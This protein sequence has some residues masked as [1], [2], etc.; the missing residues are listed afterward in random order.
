VVTRRTTLAVEK[1][2]GLEPADQTSSFAVLASPTPAQIRQQLEKILSSR[3]F[4]AAERQRALLRYVVEQAVQ[5]RSAAVKE[6]SVGVEAFGRGE[7]F[8]PR[9]DTI[10]RTEARNVRFRLARYYEQEGQ[11]DPIVIQLPKGGYTPRFVGQ[12]APPESPVPALAAEPNANPTPRASVTNLKRGSRI[13]ILAISVAVLAGAIAAGSLARFGRSAFVGGSPARDPASIAVLPFLNLTNDKEGE[14]LSDALAEELINSL[15]RIPGLHV[16]AGPSVFQYKDR[17]RDIAKAGR[18]LNVRN[19][20]KGSVSVSGGRV[21]ISAQLE[22]ASNGYQLWSASFDRKL[23]DLL[24]I[25]GEISRAIMQSLGVEL[26]GTTNVKAGDIPP[27]AIYQDYLKGLYFLNQST[28]ENIRTAIEYFER[29]V[30]SDPNFAPAYRGIADGYARIAAFTSTPSEEVIPKI[31][32]AATKALALDDNLGEAHL[33][34]ARAYSIEWNLPAAEREFHRALDLS[35]S[36]AAVH[37]Y[38]GEHLL[39]AGDLEKALA[40]GRIAM[41]LDPISPHSPQFVA[42]A[43]YYLRRYDDAIDQLHKAIDLHPSSGISHQLLGLVWLARSKTYAAGVSESELARKYMEGDP[44]I[45][46]QLGY[47]YAMTG[48]PAEARAILDQ[49]LA[50][51]GAYVRALPVAR[52]YIGLGDRDRAFE[53]LRKAVRQRDVSLMLKADPLYDGLRGDQ[54]FDALLREANLGA[55]PPQE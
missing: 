41:E 39:R 2:F 55:L 12:E 21:R 16:M 42:R 18:E 26:A 40:E 24:A 1:T 37:H 28:A 5:G 4:R 10:V 36:S 15:A 22:D 19:I 46:S 20:L 17:T 27:P 32:T 51:S 8:D 54:R 7:S 14:I 6:Y 9:Q 49:L 13:A 45:T 38:Y 31:R 47:A 53:W 52:V 30:A 3:T 11:Q 29:A 33:D 35:P 43:L 25:Q 48:K 50:G 44:W 23:D 34:L